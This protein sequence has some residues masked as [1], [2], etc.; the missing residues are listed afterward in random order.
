M[1]PLKITLPRESEA[2]RPPEMNEA[3][4]SEHEFGTGAHTYGQRRPRKQ[5]TGVQLDCLRKECFTVHNENS[6]TV[7]SVSDY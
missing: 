2:A 4:P 1:D 6:N 7:K 5:G 3:R